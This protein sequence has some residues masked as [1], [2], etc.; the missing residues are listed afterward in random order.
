M[1]A[2]LEAG[3]EDAAYVGSSDFA[4]ATASLG[5]SYVM[6][7]DAAGWSNGV[8]YGCSPE[9]GDVVAALNAGL[10][11]FKQTAAYQNLCNKY[12]SIDCDP[13]GWEFSY[14]GHPT[15]RAGG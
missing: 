12:S 8:A 11:A 14:A 15:T 7:H 3:T 10:A 1:W 9:Y 5:A 13:V 4:D 2:A 6:K